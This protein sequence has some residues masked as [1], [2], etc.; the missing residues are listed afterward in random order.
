M[1]LE[2]KNAV[3]FDLD[4]TMADSMSVWTDI[5][6]TFL[7]RETCSADTLHKE[8]EGMSFT[9][10]AEYFVRIFSAFGNGR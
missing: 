9:E 6:R 5:D 7:S 10:T 2:N 3:I 4:G 1:M 8:I